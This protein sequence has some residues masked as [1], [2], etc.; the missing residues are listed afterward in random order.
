MKKNDN[1]ILLDTLDTHYNIEL[2]LILMRVM[3]DYEWE[4]ETTFIDK[5]TGEENTVYID[6]WYI[7]KTLLRSLKIAVYKLKDT[8]TWMASDFIYKG[9]TPYGYPTDITGFTLPTN[10]Q[11]SMHEVEG[12]CWEM[13]YDN[14][15]HTSF[16][17]VIDRYAR[18]LAKIRMVMNQ[19]L[20]NQISPK[21]IK[22]QTNEKGLLPSY[23]KLFNEVEAFSNTIYTSLSTE[24]IEVLDLQTPFL[25]LD[26][27]TL[28]ERVWDRCML[29]LGIN[30][31]S[32]K[33][34]RIITDEA[35][36][37]REETSIVRA[38]RLNTRKELCKKL[39]DRFGM[40]IDVRVNSQK[41][42]ERYGSYTDR[43][44]EEPS[45]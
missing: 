1:E 25:G 40:K 4:Y 14:N 13:C 34:E 38:S 27:E 15:L 9:L 18:M 26:L 10:G 8:N 42:E 23:K 2:K 11:Q 44:T 43:D 36:M 6:S 22:L 32:D 7:E 29:E 17:D 30:T 24:N 33:K 21:L 20:F 37:D 16:Y 39:Q 35:A 19:N 3:S 31:S 41:K 28:Y 12:D 5:N 45:N